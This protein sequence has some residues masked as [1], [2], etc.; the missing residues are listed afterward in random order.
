MAATR[1]VMLGAPGAGKGT[2]A[3][4]LMA[5]LHLCH[6][7]TGDLLRAEIKSG[8]ELGRLAASL[9]NHG[10]LVPDAVVIG[11]VRERLGA[12][13]DGAGYV[14]DGFPRTVAQAE[15]LDHANIAVDAALEILVPPQDLVARVL[16][17]QSCPECGHV[18]HVEFVRS[19]DGQTCDQCGTRLVSRP[20]DTEETIRARQRVYEEKTAPLAD[21]FRS[22]GELNTI[23]GLGTPDEVF[24]RILA[25]IGVPAE[26]VG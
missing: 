6:L 20:D 17:R 1:L 19:K 13:G 5:R 7:A 4:R 23:D 21:Y 22:R 3:K 10:N 26:Q 18:F 2:Q 12:L 14:M 11:M 8:S 25:A 9:I 16:G 24:G 15:A